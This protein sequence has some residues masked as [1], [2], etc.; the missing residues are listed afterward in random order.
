MHFLL[1]P[2]PRAGC[3]SGKPKVCW[4]TRLYGQTLVFQKHLRRAILCHVKSWSLLFDWPSAG[5]R[6]KHKKCLQV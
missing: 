2:G 1:A 4:Y 5:T 3:S 6:E